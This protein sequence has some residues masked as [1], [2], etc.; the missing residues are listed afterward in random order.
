M[1]EDAKRYV[2]ATKTEPE[3]DFLCHV[4]DGQIVPIVFDSIPAAEPVAEALAKAGG[5]EWQVQQCTPA[6]RPPGE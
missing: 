6:D 2:V 5:Y 1:T 3:S 4:R